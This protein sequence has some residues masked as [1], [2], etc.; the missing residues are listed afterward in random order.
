MRE[1]RSGAA[2]TVAAA[3]GLVVALY[4]AATKL[5]G[6]PPVCGPLRGC[7]T[8]ASS[9][10]S[11]VAGIPVAVFGVAFSVALLPLGARWWRTGDRRALLATYGL[12]LLGCFVVAALTYLELFVIHAICIYCLVYA[13]TVVA[14]F[15]LAAREI[16]RAADG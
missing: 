2:M 10:Y 14:V 15:A 11:A 3:I 1:R 12:A 4:L 5:A 8:V 6:E 9:S 7:E 16:R 13:V